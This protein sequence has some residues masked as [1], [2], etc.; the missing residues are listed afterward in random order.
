VARLLL[1]AGVLFSALAVALRAQAPPQFAV[2]VEYVQIE[3]RVLDERDQPIRGL[4]KDQFQVIEDG[5]AQNVTVFS[6]VDLPVPSSTT[7]SLATTST[8]G[9]VRPDVATNIRPARDLDSRVFLLVLD[10]M[11]IDGSRTAETRRFLRDFVEHRIGPNDLVAVSSL[12]RSLGFQNF[13]TDRARLVSAI[14]RMFGTKLPS[15]TTDSYTNIEARAAMSPLNRAGDPGSGPPGVARG[16][17]AYTRAKAINETLLRLIGWMGELDAGAKSIVLVSEGVP[18]EV[19]DPNDPLT[20]LETQMRQFEL[21]Q[22]ATATR[23][24]NVP[25]YTIDPRGLTS[26]AEESIQV[27]TVPALTNTT[28][29][30]GLQ[31]ELE[32][33]RV[34]LRRLAADTGGYAFLAT[35][36]FGG[37]FDSLVRRASTYYV[38]GYYSSNPKRDGK[39]RRIQ[40]KVARPDAHVIARSGYGAPSERTVPAR[41]APGPS[42]SSDLVREALNSKFPVSALPMTMTAAAF[43]ENGSTGSVAIVLEAPGTALELSE[44]G[45]TFAA[46]LQVLVT[47]LDDRGAMKA[48]DAKDLQFKLQPA[49]FERVRQQ[50]FRWLSRLSV[51]PGKYQLRIAAAGWSKQGSVWYDLEV[52]DFSDGELAMSGVLI[53]SAARFA[54]PTLRPDPQLASVLPGPPTAAR[55]FPAGDH[56]TVFAEIYDNKVSKARDLDVTVRVRTDQGREVFRLPTPVVSDRVRAARGIVRSVTDIPLQVLPGSYVVSIEAE[57]RGDTEHRVLRE[58]PFWVVSASR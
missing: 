27:G 41:P 35:N 39:F 32:A 28:P 16:D 10:D 23:R 46:P 19:G 17:I 7:T 33:S 50:G 20:P 31:M 14:D 49:V 30:A 56:L 37:A 24:S 52:P 34:G 11:Q 48:T 1:S 55:E 47:A 12:G 43:R 38:L 26:L 9:F 42:E 21:D 4:T 58:V 13:T 6:P 8:I 3:A 54:T 45:G 15:P 22:L 44:Q 51:K 36:D 57:P 40:V 18:P 25:I 5:V 53:T 2:A 29:L